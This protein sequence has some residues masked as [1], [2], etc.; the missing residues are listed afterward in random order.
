M[1]I[2]KGRIRQA[3]VSWCYE[4][5]PLE[6]LAQYAA[7]IGLKAI[8]NV[9]PEDWPILKRHGLACAM[10]VAHGFVDGMNHKENHRECIEKLRTA[11]AANGAA[12]FPNVITFSGM[13]NGMADDV[14]LGN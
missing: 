2:T 8:E 10:T 12:G 11:I 9:A 4:P 1:D 5:M 7:A 3:V 14:G 6:T 13:R